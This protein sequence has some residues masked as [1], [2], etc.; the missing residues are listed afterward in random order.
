MNDQSVPPVLVL[1]LGNILLGD[2]GVGPALVEEVGRLYKDV[3]GVECVDGG[4]QGLALL[5]FFS[6]REAVVVLDAFASQQGAGT[7]SVLEGDEVMN[8]RGP[9]ST[10]AHEGNA[11]ELLAAA[12]LVD[13]LPERL[14][15]VG[16]EPEILR[17][18]LGLSDSVKEALPLALDRASAVIGQ[19]MS[20]LGL[21][22]TA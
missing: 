22:A 6:R 2:D 21:T 18:H 15:L 11:G 16:I 4:T 3:P 13:V 19:V 10:T 9:R 17:I 12:A 5:D 8:V 14:F 20:E 1:G 7:V